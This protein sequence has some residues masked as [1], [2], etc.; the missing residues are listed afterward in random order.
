MLDF[1]LAW[2]R[3]RWREQKYRLSQGRFVAPILSNI[4]LNDQGSLPNTKSFIY[5]ADELV[6]LHFPEGATTNL[7]GQWPNFISTAMRIT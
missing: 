1:S 6:S 5:D 4:Y 7:S 3:I 2:K